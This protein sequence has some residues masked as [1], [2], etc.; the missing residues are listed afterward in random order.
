MTA[1]HDQDKHADMERRISR[2]TGS[3]NE[4]IRIILGPQS[5]NIGLGADS[6]KSGN[7]TVILRTYLES[8]VYPFEGRLH[9]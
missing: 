7:M 1:R 3:L 5:S 6:D 9:I 4:D 8:T 2:Q